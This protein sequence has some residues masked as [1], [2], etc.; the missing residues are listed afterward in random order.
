[1]EATITQWEYKLWTESLRARLSD[2][3]F[4]REINALGEE[5]WELCGRQGDTHI[6]KRPA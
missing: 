3:R 5:G 1:M 4:Q 6:F 2:E